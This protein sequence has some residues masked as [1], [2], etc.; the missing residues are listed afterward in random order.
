MTVR[1]LLAVLHPLEAPSVTTGS[2]SDVVCTGVTHDSRDVVPGSLFV[3][4]RGLKTDG[5]AFAAAAVSAGAAAVVSDGP[6]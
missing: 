5:R 6:P 2:G 4:L 1:E 3:A